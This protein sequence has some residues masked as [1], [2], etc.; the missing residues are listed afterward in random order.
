MNR[1]NSL[2]NEAVAVLCEL[3]LTA[4]DTVVQL[5]SDFNTN[6]LWCCWYLELA[7]AK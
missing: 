1:G 6:I 2:R 4:G 5:G 3:K 7:E